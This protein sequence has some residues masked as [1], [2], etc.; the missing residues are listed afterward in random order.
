M[1]KEAIVEKTI[2]TLKKLPADKV[3]EVAEFADF[4]LKNYEENILQKGIEKLVEQ[5]DVFQ[6]LH[7]EED[8][9]T[10]DDI[11]RKY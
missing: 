11:K 5:S 3:G 1:T 8:L 9:Y 7:D 10:D 6:F 2:R 4:V